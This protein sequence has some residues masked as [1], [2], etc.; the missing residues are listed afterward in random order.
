VRGAS[1]SSSSSSVGLAARSAHTPLAQI[2]TQMVDPVNGVDGVVREWPAK[3]QC[4]EQH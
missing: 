1:S 3:G 2:L 4:C